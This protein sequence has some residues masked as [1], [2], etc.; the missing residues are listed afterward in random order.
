MNEIL[1]KEDKKLRDAT[2][3]FLIKKH[4]GTISDVCLAMK[5]RG[6]GMNRWNGAGGKV[7]NGES[8]GDAAVREV[9]EEIS[10]KLSH[11]NKVA[12][13][14]FIFA[15][16][17]AWDQMVHVYFS[18]NWEGEPSESEEMKPEWFDSSQ[19]PFASMWPDDIF[20]LPTVLA[21]KFVQSKFIFGENDTILEKEVR[22][23]ECL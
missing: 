9:S 1:V 10:V 19:L 23:V 17:S 22:E 18:E 12:E 3:V 15:K 7:E 16:N 20:W 6:F 11:L 13:L 5:K 8:I 2:L 21:G 4:Q 14:T